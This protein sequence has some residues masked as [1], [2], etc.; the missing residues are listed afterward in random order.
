MCQNVLPLQPIFVCVCYLFFYHC[1]CGSGLRLIKLQLMGGLAITAGRYHF[2]CLGSRRRPGLARTGGL[3]AP[4]CA[5]PG[6]EPLRPHDSQSWIEVGK[7]HLSF[8]FTYYGSIIQH[9][10]PKLF[11]WILPFLFFVDQHHRPRSEPSGSVTVGTATL[12]VLGQ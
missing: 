5:P 11:Q 3:D 10:A 7:I 8:A 9:Y 4:P 12:K 2:S 6:N 1:K